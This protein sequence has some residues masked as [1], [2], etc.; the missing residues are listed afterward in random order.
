M[1]KNISLNQILVA[2]GLIALLVVS[3]CTAH[4]W[5]MTA[6]GG[7]AVFAAAYFSNKVLPFIVVA[8]G[9]IISDLIIGFHNQML[10]VYGAY[11]LMVVVGYSLN[12]NS[13]R[14]QRVSISMAASLLFFLIT[15]F[16]V[17]SGGGLY[18]LTA[19]GLKQC[20]IMGLPFF[21]SQ[22][23]SDVV[24][25]FALFEV[26]RLPATAALAV[27]LKLYLSKS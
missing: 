20:Y 23:L 4:V 24:V 2:L 9:M 5:N 26:A 14:I 8:T 17:W 16:S 3:R 11:F 7:I 21:R 13:P 22:L 19:E 15:N 6:V 12:L 27:R 18:P 10:A 1:N 25:G